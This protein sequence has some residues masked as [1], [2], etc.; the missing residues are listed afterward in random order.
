MELIEQTV[1]EMLRSGY[2][3]DNVLNVLDQQIRRLKES[4]VYIAAIKESEMRP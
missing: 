4:H 1:L 2:S 3:V